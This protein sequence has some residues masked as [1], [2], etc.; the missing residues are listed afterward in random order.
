M[1]WILEQFEAL[2]SFVGDETRQGAFAI[3]GACIASIIGAAVFTIRN[4]A[5]RK[6]KVV[7]QKGS[8]G[9]ISLTIEEYDRRLRVREAEVS[10]QILQ[11]SGLERQALEAQKGELIARLS[12]IEA[13][14]S[15]AISKIKQLENTLC[16]VG[17]DANNKII[18]DAIAAIQDGD[19]SKAEAI[20]VDLQKQQEPVLDRAA[21]IAFGLGL[22]A[23]ERVDWAGAANHYQR[24][25]ILSKHD[26]ALH[27]A[28]I[29][30]HKIGAYEAAAQATMELLA[31]TK[32]RSGEQ[33]IEFAML[34]NNLAAQLY[35]MGHVDEAISR[36]KNS[37]KIQE[38]LKLNNTMDYAGSLANLANMHILKDEP[39]FAEPLQRKALELIEA[40]VGQKDERYVTILNSLAEN[41]R[42]QKKYDEAERL[43]KLVLETDLALFGDQHPHYARDL[44]FYAKLLIK[45]KRLEAAKQTLHTA[46]E[47]IRHKLPPTHPNAFHVADLLASVL[48]KYANTDLDRDVLERLRKI[49]GDDIGSYDEEL[50]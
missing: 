30:L 26:A 10:N 40:N 2:I 9:R 16:S 19:T 50:G 8:V 48:K 6:K 27:K 4:L 17:Y 42:I 46:I 45:T 36:L 49:F 25:Y 5:K 29:Y 38:E 44:H 34:T 14:Y 33:N 23:E 12:N 37:L 13:A 32:E 35:D 7:S 43:F 28:S 18:M 15:E 24:S 47:I 31:L 1:D 11:T 20:L 41:L 22:I 39:I 3:I 21:Q